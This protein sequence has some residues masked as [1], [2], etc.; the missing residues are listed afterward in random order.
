MKFDL[1]SKDVFERKKIAQ[2]LLEKIVSFLMKGKMVTFHVVHFE[3]DEWG[4][5]VDNH[6]MTP[7]SLE[8]VDEKGNKMIWIQDFEFFL[9]LL[10][11]DTRT[12][13]VQF[14][15]ERPAVIFE[16]QDFKREITPYEPE[17]ED[18]YGEKNEDSR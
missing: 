12:H 13:S 4:C 10:L 15:E 14:D 17:Q 7:I 2:L 6:Y 9:L 1:T 11:L 5:T 16:F 18:E 3:Y 8:P